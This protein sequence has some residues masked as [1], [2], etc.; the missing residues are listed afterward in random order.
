MKGFA[1]K[2]ELPNILFVGRAGTG[3]T[4][5]A[6]ALRNELGC[7]D[8][9]SFLELNASDDRGIDIVRNIIK[10]F[11]R[12]KRYADVPFKLCLLDQADGLTK[13]AQNALLRVMEM[14]HTNVRFILTANVLG[15]LSQMMISRCI[16]FHLRGLHPA[17]MR[18]L[19][20]RIATKELQGTNRFVSDFIIDAI[21]KV[22]HG[23]ARL[24]INTLE[25]IL[26]LENPTAEDV[27]QCVGRTDPTHV[28]ALL[29]RAVKGKI[30]ETFDTFNLLINRDGSSPTAILQQIFYST[31]RGSVRGLTGQQ[32]LVIL[33]H[34]GSLPYVTDDIKLASFLAR[35]LLDESLRGA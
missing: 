19:L 6:Y 30:D 26:N 14:Y 22:A 28:F 15:K 10:Q 21:V 27:F 9:S 3:K 18:T 8:G 34:L 1:A 16:I 12:Q 24:A 33:K 7:N 13:P 4:A 2:K 25:G 35:M 5:C 17:H 11:A 32:R 20:K 29:H 31:L 23:D